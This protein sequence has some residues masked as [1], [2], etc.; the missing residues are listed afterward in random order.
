MSGSRQVT[1]VHVNCPDAESAAH[2]A[3]RLVASRLAACSNTLSP[4][5]SRYWWNGTIERDQEILVILKTRRELF[6]RVADAVQQL[7]PD[8]VPSIIGHD[9]SAVNRAYEE[10]VYDSTAD[11]AD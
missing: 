2:I 11:P 3:E 6:D 9:V 1:E 10:W 4:V 5:E 7:H 8:D